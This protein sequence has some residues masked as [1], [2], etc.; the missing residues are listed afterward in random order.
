MK[1]KFKFIRL[2]LIIILCV[3]AIPQDIY[4]NGDK[5]AQKETQQLESDAPVNESKDLP[6]PNSDFQ[7]DSAKGEIVV[8]K[9][10][11]S[12]VVIPDAID[13][14]PVT[15]IGDMAFG[16]PRINRRI[17]SITLPSGL[18]S[19]EERAFWDQ[20]FTNISFP[21]GLEAIGENAF[22][23]CK[24]LEEV[25]LP[26]SVTML[27]SGTFKQCPAIRKVV[28]SA[29][30]KVI[31]SECFYP[32]GETGSLEEVVFK[33]GLEKIGAS[34]FYTQ[35]LK[36]VRLPD[37]IKII[38][39][40]A[41]AGQQN[42][43][44]HGTIYIGSSI[45][46]INAQGPSIGNPFSRWKGKIVFPFTKEEADKRG[47]NWLLEK[48]DV[49]Y[50]SIVKYE[51]NGG[52]P[53]I[54]PESVPYGELIK[55]K[56]VDMTRTG[57]TFAGWYKDENLTIPWDFTKDVV[58]ADMTLYAKWVAKEYTVKYDTQGG[59]MIPD[60]TGVNFTDSGLFPDPP[61]KEGYVFKGWMSGDKYVKAETTYDSLVSGDSEMSITL[62]ARWEVA[63][64]KLN[65]HYVFT[66]Q[67]NP[68]G[69]TVPGDITIDYGAI[70]EEV[71]FNIPENW[72]FDGWYM[73][74]ALTQ[75]FDYTKPVT[76]DT[77]LYGKWTYMKP[78]PAKPQAPAKPLKKGTPQ[79]GDTINT[80]LWLL[81][82]MGAFSF[83]FGSYM[84]KRKKSHR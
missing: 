2:L 24:D 73:N 37:S 77:T 44:Q 15:S 74:E 58:T 51:A 34:A 3:S 64:T 68:K 47:V 39:M 8:Y 31:P 46:E 50:S 5:K 59:N 25:I 84:V 70:L 63:N 12:D 27:G 72:S 20:R 7:F 36:N 10:T 6:N 33:E 56:P 32:W 66:S 35:K 38:E 48:Y 81:I 40:Q 61:V 4:A 45:E 21:D 1:K 82:M 67:N 13:G 75:K 30:L 41:F 23:N 11:S 79:T 71:K 14:V 54:L 17:T 83:V 22:V 9:G 26:D 57:Y 78:K 29:N 69:I 65:I 43:D 52:T 76:F 16:Y 60:K 80:G 42:E 19:I 49:S 18:K 28:L 53:E 62:V 55:N